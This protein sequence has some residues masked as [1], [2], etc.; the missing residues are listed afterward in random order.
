[1]GYVAGRILGV[2]F[3]TF[4]IAAL[5]GLFCTTADFMSTK[6]D[7]VA[8]GRRAAGGVYGLFGVVSEEIEHN[9]PNA[10]PKTVSVAKRIA[11]PYAVTADVTALLGGKLELAASSFFHGAVNA[12]DKVAP[13]DHSTTTAP[14]TR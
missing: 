2:I 14:I 12:A 6:Y 11:S 13:V 8:S 9:D 10:S 4:L 1:M 7:P 5:Y 3:T